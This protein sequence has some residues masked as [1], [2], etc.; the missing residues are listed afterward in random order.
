MANADLKMIFNTL[1]SN[2]NETGQ[3]RIGNQHHVFVVAYWLLV[4]FPTSP[5]KNTKAPK[6]FRFQGLKMVPRGGIEP[7]TLRFSVACSTN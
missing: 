1:A 5:A 3:K 7:P 2:L 6:T 4:K